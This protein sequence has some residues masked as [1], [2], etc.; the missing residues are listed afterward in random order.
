[1]Y[2]QSKDE[3]NKVNRQ[4]DKNLRSKKKVMLKYNFS[5]LTKLHNSPFYR[6]VKIWNTLP[7]CIQ[8]CESKTEFKRLVKRLKV[9]NLCEQK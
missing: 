4:C 6:G 9:Y 5:N 8:K 1:M 3:M 2:H 7:E